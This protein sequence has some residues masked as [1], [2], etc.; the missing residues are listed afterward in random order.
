M[1]QLLPYIVVW[2]LVFLAGFVDAIG[3]GGGL[4]SLPAYVIAGLPMHSALGTNKLSSCMGTCLATTRMAR[5]GM[6]RWKRALPCAAM[7]LLGSGCGA[8]LAMLIPDQAFRVILLFVLPATTVYIMRS[9]VL[10]SR[11]ET[12]PFRTELTICLCVSLAIG[13]YDGIYG[14]GTGTFL[15]LAFLSFAH[16]SLK[17]AAGTAKVVNL[18][19]NVAAVLVFLLHGQ[20]LFFLGITA[21]LFNMA[22]AWLGVTLFKEKG[23]RVV[24]PIML[25]VLALFLLKTLGELTGLI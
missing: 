3:G 14:P 2:P 6:V 20:V 16:L 25:G 22:G 9:R 13:V 7:G 18:C 1:E 5:S 24:K 15:I 4:I 10:E 23:A 11:K 19:T 21:G 17:E 8:S 12:L